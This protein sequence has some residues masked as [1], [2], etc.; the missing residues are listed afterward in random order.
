MF[1]VNTTFMMSGAAIKYLCAV[2]N[3]R[4]ITWYMGN[5]ALS[6]GMGVTRWIR[7]TVED[8]P[9]PSLTEAKQRPFVALVDRILDAKGADAAA[10]TGVLEA[11][12]DGLVYALYGLTAEEIAAIG[13][14]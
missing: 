14:A 11:G 13:G 12:L 6:S 1:C 7:H 8:I 2:L 3:S 9:I 10:D 5:T 4:L